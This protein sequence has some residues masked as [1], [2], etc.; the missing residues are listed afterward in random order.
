MHRAHL[1]VDLNLLGLAKRSKH[2][3]GSFFNEDVRIS[4]NA[5]AKKNSGINTTILEYDLEGT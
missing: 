5:R 1:D 2:A 4:A 3:Q